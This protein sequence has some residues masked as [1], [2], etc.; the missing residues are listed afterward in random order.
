M[1]KYSPAVL[2][3]IWKVQISPWQPIKIKD[4]QG[5][6]MESPVIFLPL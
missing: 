4:P 5:T 3:L 1:I 2:I 6:T